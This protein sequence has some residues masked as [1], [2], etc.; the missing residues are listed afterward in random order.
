MSTTGKFT[1]VTSRAHQGYSAVTGVTGYD[2]NDS[3]EM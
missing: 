2:L 3:S 1:G